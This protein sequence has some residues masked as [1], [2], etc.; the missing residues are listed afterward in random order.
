[1]H[2]HNRPSESIATVVTPGNPDT[3]GG[4]WGCR[5]KAGGREMGGD[6]EK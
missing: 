3:K 1:M 4:R 2:V 6:L 5:E